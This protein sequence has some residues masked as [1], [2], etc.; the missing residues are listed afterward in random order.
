MLPIY[1]KKRNQQSAT[2]IGNAAHWDRK[3][4]T[5]AKQEPEIE[6]VIRRIYEEDLLRQEVEIAIGVS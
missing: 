4:L 5:L 3:H 2:S 1:L 6:D